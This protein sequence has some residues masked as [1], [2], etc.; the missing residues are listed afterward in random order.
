MCSGLVSFMWQG[1][2]QL[3]LDL[4]GQ[5][6][7]GRHANDLFHRLT[8][9]EDQNGRDTADAVFHGYLRI[10]I[11]IELSNRDLIGVIMREFLNDWTDHP[12]WTT[13]FGP[14]VYNRNATFQGLFLKIRISEFKCHYERFL[15]RTVIV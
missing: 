15:S 2:D 12:A 8:I 3:C 5:V 11:H 10:M 1:S 4:G 9:L 13:P 14:K 6:L 7:F